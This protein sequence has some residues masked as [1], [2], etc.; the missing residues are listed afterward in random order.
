MID[1]LTIENDKI[2]PDINCKSIPELKA[3]IEEYKDSTNALLFI[4]HMTSPFSSYINVPEEDKEE[5]L[6]EDFPGDYGVEDEE[7]GNAINKLKKLYLTPTRRFFLNSK[8]TL[9]RM[10]EYMS[11][12]EITTGRDGNASVIA[13]HLRN[14]GKT[15]KE[16]KELEKIYE[17][18]T[19]SGVRGGYSISYDEI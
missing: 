7:I 18:E 1:I 2:V 10:G 15:I 19:Q 4:Y 14:V 11:T 13:S 8:T 16:F 3:V 5:I 17:E 6:L 9:E 12:A